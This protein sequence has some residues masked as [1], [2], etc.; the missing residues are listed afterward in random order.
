LRQKNETFSTFK[1][2]K[3]LVQTGRKITTLKTDNDLEFYEIEF[4]EL[5]AVNGITRHKTLVGKPQQKELQNASI[6][7]Y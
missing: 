7:L 2:F 1:K 3:T 4:N 6:G 5:C